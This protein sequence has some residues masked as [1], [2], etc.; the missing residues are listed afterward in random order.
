M[1]GEEYILK[2]IAM[3]EESRSYQSVKFIARDGVCCVGPVLTG[4]PLSVKYSSKKS[5][6][7]RGVK[8]HKRPCSDPV[9][10]WM[11]SLAA[12]PSLLHN[13]SLIQC[14]L[15]QL[16]NMAAK[17]N[18]SIDQH[19][20]ALINAMLTGNFNAV[21]QFT[22]FLESGWLK[23]SPVQVSSWVS[24]RSESRVCRNIQA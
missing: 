1:Y 24:P 17:E 21:P 13:A 7:L 16:R 4:Q 23:D 8:V 18:I 6:K 2:R 22:R 20:K 3:S 9:D 11:Q 10:Q 15:V 14:G 19:E 5:D 12:F